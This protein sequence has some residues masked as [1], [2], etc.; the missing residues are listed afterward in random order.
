MKV[1]IEI[2]DDRI[3]QLAK[4]AMDSTFK[5]SYPQ[6]G[7]GLRLIENAV[8]ER[9]NS[10]EFRNNLSS[11]TDDFFVN[12]A[13]KIIRQELLNT[14]ANSI[15]DLIRKDVK[16]RRAAGE[17]DEIINQIFERLNDATA[18]DD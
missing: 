17:F 7:E 6:R 1:E 11:I 4:A 2:S 5:M 13:P 8:N 12:H 9:V 14:L 15:K 10:Q 18:T 3:N 16:K